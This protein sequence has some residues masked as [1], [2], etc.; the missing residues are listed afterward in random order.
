MGGGFS[1]SMKV[2]VFGSGCLKGGGR[3]GET[4]SASEL[5]LGGSV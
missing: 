2:A 5:E 1:T 4:G 3:V